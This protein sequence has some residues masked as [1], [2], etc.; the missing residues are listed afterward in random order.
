[1]S[2]SAV[3]WDIQPVANLQELETIVEGSTREVRSQSAR[4]L[5]E[6]KRTAYLCEWNLPLSQPVLVNTCVC[7]FTS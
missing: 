3:P 6:S 4:A 2:S 5:L 1:M 7:I